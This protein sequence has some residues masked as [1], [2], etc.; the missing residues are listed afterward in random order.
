MKTANRLGLDVVV[1]V[2]LTAENADQIN[3][4]VDLISTFS[5]QNLFLFVPHAEGRGYTLNPV[6]FSEKSLA[7][8]NDNSKKFFNRKLYQ[9]E[10]EWMAKRNFQ[11]YHRRMLTVVLNRHNIEFFEHNSLDETIAYV[12]GLDD[13]Y[14]RRIPSLPELA[15]RY[16]DADSPLFYRQ[17]D[18]ELKYEKQFIQDYN[19]SLYDIHDET[20][21]FTRHIP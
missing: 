4:L 16:C 21:C 15:E 2:A 13:D 9:T 17:R 11:E 18:L 10:A 5:V 7:L 1:G 6:R 8:L 3:E 19:L 12:E 14:Y 20:H